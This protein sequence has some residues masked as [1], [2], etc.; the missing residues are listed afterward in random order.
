[1][2]AWS[3]STLAAGALV[4]EKGM[5]RNYI[6]GDASVKTDFDVKFRDNMELEALR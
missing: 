1:M 5:R 3:T 4:L 6:E 2:T